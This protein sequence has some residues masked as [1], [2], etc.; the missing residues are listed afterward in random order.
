MLGV[1]RPVYNPFYEMLQKRWE[2]K[3]LELAKKN[4]CYKEVKEYYEIKERLEKHIV[5]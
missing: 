5:Y 2:K 4:G 1:V 3:V